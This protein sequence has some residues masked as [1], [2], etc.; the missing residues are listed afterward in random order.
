MAQGRA[1][2]LLKGSQSQ[3][4]PVSSSGGLCSQVPGAHLDDPCLPFPSCRIYNGR[5]VVKVGTGEVS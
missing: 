1:L 3:R 4:L 5:L 2:Q